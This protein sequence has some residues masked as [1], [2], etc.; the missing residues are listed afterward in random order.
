MGTN[1]VTRTKHRRTSVQKKDL[2]ETAKRLKTGKSPGVDSIRAKTVKIMV[3]EHSEYCLKVMNKLI[4]NREF[5]IIWK[6]KRLENKKSKKISQ[7][8]K[9]QKGIIEELI[10]KNMPEYLTRVLCSH[11]TNRKLHIGE[12]TKLMVTCEIAQGSALGPLL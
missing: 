6:E 2:E 9:Q 5:P 12:E 7:Q 4:K 11:F 10:R 3:R 8:N 1:T